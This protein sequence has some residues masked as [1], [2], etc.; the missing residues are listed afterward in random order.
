[1]P[2][3]NVLAPER[4]QQQLGES[5]IRAMDFS[6]Y[7]E[8][9]DNGETLT[10][11]PTVTVTPSGVLTVG[12]TSIVGS[13]VRFRVSGG[14]LLSGTTERVFRFEVLVNTSASNILEGDG[15]LILTD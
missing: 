9:A 11:T 6:H 5:R 15:I 3:A 12:A 2:I 10:G 1:M 8:I 13:Q 7:P 14:A 4:P